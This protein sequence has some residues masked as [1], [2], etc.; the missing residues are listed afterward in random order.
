MQTPPDPEGL[1]AKARAFASGCV[2]G[3][4]IVGA[5]LTVLGLAALL[6]VLFG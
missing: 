6:R 3:L 1:D 4:F 5:L 2:I